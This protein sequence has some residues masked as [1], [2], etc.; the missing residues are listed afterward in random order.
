[1]PSYASIV[2]DVMAELPE[3]RVGLWWIP[4][5]LRDDFA[6]ADA[7]EVRER[8]LALVH[9]I[10]SRPGVHFGQFVSGRFERWTLA[11]DEVVERIDQDWRRLGRPPDIGEIG[12]FDRDLYPCPVCAFDLDFEPWRQGSPSHE[13]CPCCGIQFGYHDSAGGD[14]ARARQVY[15][16]WRE[17]WIGNGARWSSVGRRPPSGWAATSQLA[18]LGVRVP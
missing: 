2:D 10:L 16:N 12:W 14:A 8:S 11:P 4:S 3:D 17:R 9:E 6:I 15:E 1:M 18:K 7:D 13:I 5:G